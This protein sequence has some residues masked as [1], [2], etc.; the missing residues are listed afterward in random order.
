MITFFKIEKNGYLI[1]PLKTLTQFYGQKNK[2]C[3]NYHNM[4]VFNF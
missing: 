1:T 2:Q 3:F 4:Q